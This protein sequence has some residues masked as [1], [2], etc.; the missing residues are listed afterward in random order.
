MVFYKK[1]KY[2]N[3]K[4]IINGIK[5]DSLAEADYYLYLKSSSIEIIEMQPK[6]YLT[7]A[8]ILYKPDFLIKENGK[9]IYIDVK[10]VVTPVFAIKR[11][12]WHRYGQGLLR[13]IKKVGKNFIISKETLTVK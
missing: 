9:L 12:L 4:T 6:V 1:N 3:K 13:E 2:N 11:R 5:F 7:E 10:G 8:K